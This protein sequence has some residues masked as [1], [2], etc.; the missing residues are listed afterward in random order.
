MDAQEGVLERVLRIGG[1]AQNTV[2]P[3]VEEGKMGLDE[4]AEGG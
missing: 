1:I 4:C 2:D 3:V